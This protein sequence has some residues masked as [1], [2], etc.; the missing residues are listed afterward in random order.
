MFLIFDFGGNGPVAL[1]GVGAGLTTA[2]VQLQDCSAYRAP[3]VRTTDLSPSGLGSSKYE[4]FHVVLGVI[5]VHEAN[6]FVH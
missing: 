6:I 3:E 1:V 2:S 5:S 4:R